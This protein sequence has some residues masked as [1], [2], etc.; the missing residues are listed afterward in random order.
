MYYYVTYDDDDA[1]DYDGFLWL[2]H[3]VLEKNKGEISTI[4][5]LETFT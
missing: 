3:E 1:N 2:K 5:Y 4:K